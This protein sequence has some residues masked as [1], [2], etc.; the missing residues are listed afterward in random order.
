M[1][2]HRNTAPAGIWRR[3]TKALGKLWVEMISLPD[4]GQAAPRRDPPVEFFRFPP[5]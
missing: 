1:T 4:R 3:T 5:F 2:T